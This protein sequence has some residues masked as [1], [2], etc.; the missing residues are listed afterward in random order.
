MS[1]AEQVVDEWHTYW[2]PLAAEDPVTF[3]QA[4]V[5]LVSR[6]PACPLVLRHL[7]LEVTEHVREALRLK[8]TA[9]ILAEHHGQQAAVKSI[10][11]LGL[12]HGGRE[13]VA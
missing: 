13:E 3:A 2:Q 1:D 6:T 11:L 12:W 4:V 5:A 10:R 7:A 8:A 9:A